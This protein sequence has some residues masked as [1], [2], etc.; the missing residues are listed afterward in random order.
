MFGSTES[1]K[2]TWNYFRRILTYMITIPQR[3]KKTNIRTTCLG[4]TAFRLGK[5]Y[6]VAN[7]GCKPQFGGKLSYWVGDG[8]PGWPG[9]D[10]SKRLSKVHKYLMHLWSGLLFTAQC[11]L[12]QSAVLRSHVVSLSVRPS[13]C[14]VGGLWSHRLEVLETIAQT[15]SPT[16]SIFAAERRST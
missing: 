5:P 15:I 1:E 11:T 13:V 2:V 4:S 7:G 8:S 12:V 6:I 16:P 3:H 10:S 9:Y 14:D